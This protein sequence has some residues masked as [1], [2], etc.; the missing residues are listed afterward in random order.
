[1]LVCALH[2]HEKHVRLVDGETRQ[3][4]RAGWGDWFASGTAKSISLGGVYWLDGT[5]VSWRGSP[6]KWANWAWHGPVWSLDKVRS[7]HSGLFSFGCCSR[8]GQLFPHVRSVLST[9]FRVVHSSAVD[10]LS[11]LVVGWSR[12]RSGLSEGWL[13]MWHATGPFGVTM[14]GRREV[15][16][17]VGGVSVPVAS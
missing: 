9:A 6:R 2:R 5:K 13:W 10:G 11:V 1:M 15:P 16:P 3:D 12:E 14:L 4:R 7:K 8:S 17:R